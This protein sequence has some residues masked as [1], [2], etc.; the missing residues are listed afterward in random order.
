MLAANRGETVFTPIVFLPGAVDPKGM[1]ETTVPLVRR[2]FRD[3]VLRTF[4][5]DLDAWHAHG[6]TTEPISMRAGFRMM[7]WFP[8][9]RATFM[10]RLAHWLRARNV[11]GL[12]M[13]LVQLNTALHGI[14]LPPNITIGPGLYLPHTVGS[15]INAY[16]I[17]SNVTLQGGITV[18]LRTELG[19]PDIRDNVTIAA[20]ARVLGRITIGEGAT[21]GANAV[22]VTDV[23]PGT[24]MVGIPA[25]PLAK[26]DEA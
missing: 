22:V 24:T 4:Q 23:P 15:V 21:I 2:S 1:T 26:S 7:L 9:L 3:G 8:G 13:V 18:G 6:W 20:G 12:P 11:P 10:H 19:F 5:T 17:G 25:R 14:E 16:R